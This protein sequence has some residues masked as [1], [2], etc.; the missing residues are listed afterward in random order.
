[1]KTGRKSII[2]VKPNQ[3]EDAYDLDLKCD[4]LGSLYSPNSI[5]EFD[6]LCRNIKTQVP[7]PNSNLRGNRKLIIMKVVEINGEI[8][9][10]SLRFP[11]SNLAG[12]PGNASD[13]FITFKQVQSQ[14]EAVPFYFKNAD[15]VPNKLKGI[16]CTIDPEQNK[17][18]KK[19]FYTLQDR[20][21]SFTYMLDEQIDKLAKLGPK[22]GLHFNNTLNMF[23]T[24]FDVSHCISTFVDLVPTKPIQII[25]D[26]IEDL[27]GHNAFIHVNNIAETAKIV[28]QIGQEMDKLSQTMTSIE[29][30]DFD[31]LEIKNQFDTVIEALW[32]LDIYDPITQFMLSLGLSVVAIIA[33][34]CTLLACFCKKFKQ[35]VIHRL[36]DS[37][38]TR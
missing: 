30:G 34:A 15:N 6:Q 29:S 12:E 27:L 21:Q 19:N 37:Y 33:L 5:S 4:Q 7:Y 8:K 25:K 24:T 28:K 1:M 38:K 20:T 32:D 2:I 22:L 35:Q 23:S 14:T 9:P 26:Q 16:L 18:L 17:V 13:E 31:I 10:F 36:V 3:N 11:L